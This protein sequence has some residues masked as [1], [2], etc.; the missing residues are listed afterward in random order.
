MKNSPLRELG[1]D[2]AR[3]ARVEAWITADIQAERCHGAH[4]IVAR[5]G[6]VALEIVRGL[7]DKAAGKPLAD[8]AVFCSLSVGKQFTTALVLSL[9]ERGLLALHA[10]VASV[11]PEFGK[12]GKERV[13]L[14]QLLT[15]TSGV[16]ATIPA[17]PPTVLG[18]ID[19]LT[20]YACGS[21]L[22]SRP[23]E[24]VNY[25]IVLAHAVMA[26]M[27][28]RVDGRGRTFAQMLNDVVFEPLKMRDSTLGVRADLLARYCPVRCA[29]KEPG[30][31]SPEAI[32]GIGE[33]I[34]MPG[35]ELPA[36]GY[37]T[38]AR[39]M[40]RFAEMLRRGGELDGV[41]ILAP[42][43]IEF[44]TRNQTGEAPNELWNYTTG[45]RGWDPFPAYLGVGFFLRGEK[46]TPGPFGTFNSPRTF[47][48]IG[49]GSTCFWIDP[50]RDLT[51]AFASTGLMEDCFHLERMARLSDL[52]VTSLVD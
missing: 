20:Q 35:C 6:Q 30:L 4:L 38:S 29:Y 15:Q 5:R 11:I 23:G 1:F 42:A 49:A 48:G 32:E 19:K 47:G 2:E 25:S 34:Q 46:P 21:A 50:V 45:F 43:T 14:F 27:C 18:S 37:L 22:E 40:H 28:L 16:Q 39:D 8:N 33:L 9:V 7:A 3:L 26:S 41:Q 12:L 10:P 52:V 17:V 36:G 13:T 44:C 31:F 24:R 51:L